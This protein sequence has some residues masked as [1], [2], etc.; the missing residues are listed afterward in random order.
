[1]GSGALQSFT[2]NFLSAG[3]AHIK[4]FYITPVHR[5]TKMTAKGQETTNSTALKVQLVMNRNCKISRGFL[6][7]GKTNALVSFLAKQKCIAILLQKKTKK[8]ICLLSDY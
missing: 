8:A 4:N 7:I 3:K 1:M 5:A 6:L 2:N